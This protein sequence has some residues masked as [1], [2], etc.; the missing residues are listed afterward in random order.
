M[1]EDF[2]Q[3]SL[4]GLCRSSQPIGHDSELSESIARARAQGCL[5][6]RKSQM[7]GADW[8]STTANVCRVVR[9]SERTSMVVSP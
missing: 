8:P 3:S 1:L 5:L 9:F 6:F 2:A 4:T 7:S